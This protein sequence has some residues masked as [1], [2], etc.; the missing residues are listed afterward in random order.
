MKK[1][2]LS[3]MVVTLF[4]TVLFSQ[5]T[6]NDPNAEKRTVSGFHGIEISTGIELILS[7]GNM[8]EIAVSAATPE[9][10][11]KIIT[12][13]ENGILKIHYISK[14][15]SINK[16]KETKNLKAYVS[17]QKLDLLNV[18]TGA[19]VKIQGILKSSSLDLDASTGALVKGE[20]DITSLK[21]SQHTGS[22]ITL[23]GKVEKLDVTGNTGSKF[24]GEDMI[25]S[26]CNV[27]VSTGAIV[28]VNANNELQVKTNTGGKVHYKGNPSV[29]EIKNTTGGTVHKI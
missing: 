27:S 20:V 18:S 3:F 1:I 25:T 22:K 21:I 24:R 4:S 5:S 6:F 23:T 2:F 9:F 11:D 19:D 15:K 10:R 26:V 16:T 29:K 14:T 12:Q 7:E 8:E 17:Y 28:T 13:V